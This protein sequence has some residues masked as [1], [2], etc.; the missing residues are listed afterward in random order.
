M[1]EFLYT[2][3]YTGL[4]VCAIGFLLVATYTASALDYCESREEWCTAMAISVA[5]IGLSVLS[6]SAF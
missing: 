3:G 2:P 4:L 5:C 6:L 1:N